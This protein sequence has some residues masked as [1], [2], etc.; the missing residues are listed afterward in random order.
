MVGSTTWSYGQGMPDD[1]LVSTPKAAEALGV[2]RVALWRWWKKGLVRPEWT[3]PGGHAR[4][5][6][7]KLRQQ[8][9]A[10]TLHVLAD[11]PPPTETTAPA[12]EN[13]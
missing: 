5:D 8:V 12:A 4:W 7:E 2:D 11:H 3:T 10:R 9:G 13:H 6:I 1:P